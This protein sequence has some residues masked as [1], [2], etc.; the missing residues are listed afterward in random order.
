MTEVCFIRH[1][2]TEWNRIGKIQGV[3]DIPLNE[4]GKRQAR[5][6]GEHL[7]NEDW[8]ALICSTLSRTKQTAEI[9]GT[10]IGIR[11]AVEMKEFVERDNGA[12]EGMTRTERDARFPEGL[13]PGRE[14]D[15]ELSG[16]A[17]TGLEKLLKTFPGQK[18]LVVAHGGIIKAL[19]KE[20]SEENL[21]MG[22]LRLGN[23]SI[24][25]LFHS[26]GKWAVRE[27]NGLV[28]LE[29]A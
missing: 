6:A 29:K 18:I 25:R 17:M 14:S 8:D 27:M 11:E 20:L 9:I 2:E 5:L 1:G 22:R 12:A 19:L 15:E 24:N 3:A 28:H 23:T 26:K 16:R 10:F 7:Q 4:T 21:E 13:I